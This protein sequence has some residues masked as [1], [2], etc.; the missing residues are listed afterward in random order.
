MDKEGLYFLLL[1]A[2]DIY[3]NSPNDKNIAIQ[4]MKSYIS[5]YHKDNIELFINEFYEFKSFIE[6]IKDE[7]INCKYVDIDEATKLLNMGKIDAIELYDD[8]CN[9]VFE[10]EQILNDPKCNKNFYKN[11]D[12]IKAVAKILEMIDDEEPVIKTWK[13]EEVEAL[14]LNIEKVHPKTK[15]KRYENKYFYY[16]IYFYCEKSFVYYLS[17]MN[18]ILYSVFQLFSHHF[19][20]IIQEEEYFYSDFNWFI[21][22][23]YIEKNPMF[24]EEI[25]SKIDEISQQIKYYKH[26]DKYDENVN[27][28]IKIADIL[29]V[30]RNEDVKIKLQ[31]IDDAVDE[32]ENEYNIKFIKTDFNNYIIWAYVIKDNYFKLIYHKYS[33]ILYFNEKYGNN[34]F[35]DNIDYI[36]VYPV[37]SEWYLK[38]FFHN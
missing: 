6:D 9:K 27:K 20:K 4:F 17:K 30:K 16:W 1:K 31:R 8:V 11:I 12:K 15:F 29:N 24:I 2:E 23:S 34:E 14:V 36:D 35:N 38:I 18:N 19:K 13:Y 3:Y 37:F 22:E 32:V 33:S 25:C 28:I 5:N 26:A 7:L 21:E 10:F